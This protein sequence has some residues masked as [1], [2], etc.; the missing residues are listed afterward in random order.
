M[1]RL[2]IIPVILI[3]ALLIVSPVYA[4]EPPSNKSIP[5]VKVFRNLLEAGDSLYVFEYELA[6]ASDNY[7]NTPASESFIF[8]IYDVDGVTK[9]AD[10]KPYAFPLFESNGYGTGCSSFY[11]AADDD[12]PAWGGAAKIE[13]YGWPAYF[14]TLQQVDYTLVD[15]DYTDSTSQDDN[16]DDLKE[17]V[18]LLADRL[19]AD[20]QDVS[21]VLKTSSD[22]D[23]ILSQD[24][25]TY[26]RGT[27]LGL[28]ALCPEL[29]YIQVYIPEIMPTSYN[30]TMQDTYTARLAVD[31]LGD[32]FTNL[33]AVMG[34]TGAFAASA[35]WAV[36]SIVICILTSR[37]GWG[38]EIGFVASAIMLT[39]FAIIVGDVLFTILMIIALAG[40]IGIVYLVL[41]K[42]A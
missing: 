1:K 40:G 10:V 16:R 9:L 21:V 3:V 18:L 37:K 24:G 42:R 32:G 14:D 2:I 35:I 33:G 23:I 36:L 27:I 29:F 12:A 30:M 39:F 17:Y 25:E 19:E 6:Y 41:L 26:F 8:R 7:S 5:D 20:Y 28:R 11:F 4:I 22:S 15:D 34:T 31:D 38:I 13:L